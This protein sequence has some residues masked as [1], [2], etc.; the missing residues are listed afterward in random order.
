MAVA[1]NSPFSMFCDLP[2]F[3][4]RRG[5]PRFFGKPQNDK[6]QG[7]RQSLAQNEKVERLEL[8]VKS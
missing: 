6:G 8:R 1:R 5:A 4:V 7:R 2:P 3:C